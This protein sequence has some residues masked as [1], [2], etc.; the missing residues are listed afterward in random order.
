VPQETGTDENKGAAAACRH[1]GQMLHYSIKR[2]AQ[3]APIRPLIIN[4]MTTVR[5]KQ[6]RWKRRKFT[7]GKGCETIKFSSNKNQIFLFN[8]TER[9]QICTIYIYVII[10]IFFF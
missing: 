8:N 10:G 4:T 2:N 1:P 9:I 6:R 7:V 5:V 3:P